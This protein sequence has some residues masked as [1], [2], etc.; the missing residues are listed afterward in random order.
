MAFPTGLGLDGAAHNP[1]AHAAFSGFT[2][3]DPRSANRAEGP[4]IDIFEWYPSYQ[5]CQR[6]FLDHAQHSGPVQAVAAFLNISLPFQR[7]VP[8]TNYSSTTS[9]HAGVSFSW[10]P[11]NRAG[12]A[13]PGARAQPAH[14]VSLIPY[15]RRLVATGFDYPGV[16]HGFFGD[17]WAKGVG[18]MHEQERRNYLFAAKSGGWASVKRDYDI[19]P[20]ESVPFLRPLQGALDPEIEAAEKTWSEW[21]AMEDWM[22]GSRAPEVIAEAS[23]NPN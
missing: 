2:S 17:D 1:F 18:P 3:P 8:V 14:W 6:Y 9:S 20:H 5:S 11:Q 10:T 19:S 13:F 12:S 7:E 16:L 21:L 23:S 4:H 15:I 22:V